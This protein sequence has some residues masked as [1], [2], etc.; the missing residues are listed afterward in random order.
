MTLPTAD[1]SQNKGL[2]LTAKQGSWQQLGA[3]C[4]QIRHKVFVKE[5]NIPAKDELDE[6]DAS[7]EHFLLFIN[8]R[9]IAT[10]R[11][12]SKGHLGRLAV[13]KPLRGKGLATKLIQRVLQ[14]CKRIDLKQ[15]YLNAQ[16]SAVNLYAKL[17]FKVNGEEY[18]EVGIMHLPMMLDLNAEQFEDTQL[19]EQTLLTALTATNQ[20]RIQGKE[21][22]YLT[23]KLLI[24]QAGRSFQL[25][26]PNYINTWFDE[27]SLA[28]LIQLAR[29]HQYSKVQCLLAKTHEFSRQSNSLLKLQ[30]RLPSHIDIRQA[31][32]LYQTKQQAYLLIDDKHLLWWPD[33]QQPRAEL[34]T[35]EHRET[36]RFSGIF[37][38]HWEKSQV[39]KTLQN[40]NL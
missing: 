30:Q 7:S 22:I 3:T 24:Q 10:A 26:T 21:Q 15:V 17:G 6:Q 11:L 35:G 8:D 19:T 13:L 37:K 2:K 18:D 31:H 23:I 1:L 16:I 27:V 33:H 14:H 9:P 34:Y 29:R 4:R 25:E 28:P 36:Y 20:L 12:T 5:Q 32:P 39:V 40:I 38:L